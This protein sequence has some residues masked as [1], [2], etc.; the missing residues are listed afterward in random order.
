MGL[1]EETEAEVV[2]VAVVA[3]HFLGDLEKRER[4]GDAL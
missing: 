2:T 4:E 1:K 3:E